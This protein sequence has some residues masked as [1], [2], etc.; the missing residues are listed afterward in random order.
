MELVRAGKNAR[1]EIELVFKNSA[2][3][4]S[5]TYDAVVFAIPFSTLREVELEG[6]LGLPAWK[7]FAIRELRYGTNAKMMVGFDGRP[8]LSQGRNGASYSDISHHQTTWETNPTRATDLRAV[9]TDYSGGNRGAGLNP[10]RLRWKLCFSSATSTES[11]PG[12]WPQPHAQWAIC[13]FTLSIGL[14][15]P[16]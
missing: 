12:R 14:R 10:N 9:L 7:L 1:G 5:K 13:A 3:T 16:S 2:R 15:I 11:T 8:W 6:S 4:V